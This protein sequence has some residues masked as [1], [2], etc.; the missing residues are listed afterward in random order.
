[1]VP[2]VH[3]LRVAHGFAASAALGRIDG[4]AA[5]KTSHLHFKKL[6][7]LKGCEFFCALVDLLTAF[8]VDSMLIFSKAVLIEI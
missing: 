1:M 3:S 5:L 4:T 8:L 7:N 2:A 6:A